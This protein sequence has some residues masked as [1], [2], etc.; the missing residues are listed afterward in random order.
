MTDF[1]ALL[2][3]DRGQTARTVHLVNESGFADWLKRQSAEDRALIDAHRFDATKANAFVILPRGN[4]FEV[5]AAVKDSAELSPWCLA[6]LAEALPEG[7]YKLAESQLGKAALG[8]LLAQHRF[9]DY[10]SKNDPPADRGP[11]V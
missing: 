10:R 1:A 9:D 2:Q 8:W 5:V 7:T 4:G 3:P 6:R 11:R